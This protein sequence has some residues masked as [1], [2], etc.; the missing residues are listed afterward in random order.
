[1][2]KFISLF[3]VVFFTTLLNAQ[4]KVH[5]DY[6]AVYF[7][8]KVG[9]PYSI[10]KPE[11]F[12]SK[13]A[14][15]RREKFDIPINN[16]DLPVSPKY[17]KSL[18]DAGFDV[19]KTSKWLNCAII[20]VDDSKMFAKLSEMDFVKMKPEPQPKNYTYK[21]YKYK[22]TK[23]K[24][25][26]EENKY[27]Y[28]RA[29][30]QNEMLNIQALHNMGYTGKGVTMAILD[31]GFFHVDELPA[32]EKLWENNQIKGWYDFVDM[33]TTIFDGGTHG[34]MVLST[35][36]G[37]TEKLVGTA[38]DAE[39]WLFVTEDGDSEYPIEEY[40]Y[41]IAAEKADSIGCDIIHASLGYSD[42]DDDDLDYTYETLD[43]NTAIS[44]IGADIAASK[45]ILVTTSAGNEGNDPWK[46]ISAPADADS[47]LSVG[48]VTYK[49]GYGY[50]SSQGPTFD[51]RVKPDVCAQGVS[52]TVQRSSGRIGT[53]DGTSFSGPIMSGAVACL[54]QAYP[55]KSN[56]EI[57]EAIIRISSQ[58]KEPDEKLGYG[59]PD[60]YKAFEF[61]K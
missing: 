33:D 15:E 54:V 31:G 30:T 45:G 4:V 22:K 40:N 24:P 41:V 38:P 9:T 29:T 42:F 59:I 56:M 57:I 21:P 36:G 7:K 12:L 37:N 10:D 3:L 48:A 60:F 34:M 26:K 51:G 28:G 18:E 19:I 11:E 49:G 50:F 43:G 53:A 2:R 5:S 35:I 17:V 13:K 16:Q 25:P 32:F 46:Y 47:C 14:I 44:T 58:A 27:D 1:M 39:F 8:D 61:L 6:Y 23:I 52:S 55:D 20:S